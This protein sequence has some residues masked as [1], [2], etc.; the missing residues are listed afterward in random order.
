MQ[1]DVEN[2]GFLIYSNHSKEKLL[3]LTDTFYCKYK[4]KNLDY[5]MVEA[6]YSIDI[7]DKNIS[8]GYIPKILKKRLLTSHF[9]IDNLKSFL[10]A[11]DLLKV[12]QIYLIHLSTGNSDS[13]LFKLE[14]EK[15]TGKPT[16]ILG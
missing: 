8:A 12:K 5:L 16:E 11:N 7:L 14:I 10:K 4:F 9:S 15:L 6:N 1:H 2:V 13:K 3:F